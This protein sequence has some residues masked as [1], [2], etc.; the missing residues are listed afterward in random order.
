MAPNEKQSESRSRSTPNHG[1]KGDG[2]TTP[3]LPQTSR[4]ASQTSDNAREPQPV[5]VSEE[6]LDRISDPGQG[7]SGIP[8]MIPG[9]VADLFTIRGY[10][11]DHS[12]PPVC[13]PQC[14]APA[15]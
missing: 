8:P 6:I 10:Y 3:S 5:Y 11:I 13:Y 9:F 2:Y 14:W 7:P 15:Q 1:N 12:F 4:Q